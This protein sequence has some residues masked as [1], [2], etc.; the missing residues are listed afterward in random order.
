MLPLARAA[1]R[2]GHEVRFATG[3]DLVERVRSYGFDVHS[4]GLSSQEINDR[5]NATYSD[6]DDLPPHERL[7]KVVPRL[8][9]DIGARASLP[10]ILALVDEW[11]PDLIVS[12]QSESAGP[13]VATARGIPGV[14]HGWGPRVPRALVDVVIPAIEALARE[15]FP[16]VQPDAAAFPY[17]D[18]CPPGLQV[19][20]DPV[21]DTVLPLRHEDPPVDGASA[22]LPE[23]LIYVTLGTV[24]NDQEGVFETVL[25]GLADVDAPILVTVGPDVDPAR[26]AGFD[27][28]VERFVPQG[29]VFPHCR[30]VV[31]HA[32]AG[33]MLG[34]LAA[35]L[36][37]VLLPAGAEQFL[38][39]AA[40]ASAGAAEVTTP[41]G[42]G[43]A[44]ARLGESHL[45]AAR[46][47][48]TEIA[49]MPTADETLETLLSG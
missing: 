3:P 2:A 19:E 41:D 43:E 22:D 33:T 48:Q 46:R 36:P 13:I 28:M 15:T 17:V 29:L 26:L 35:G 37:Q 8:F 38:N 31:A 6:T 5:Y 4:V 12:E 32:G 20:P 7:P 49:A 16:G 34:A 45:A 10:D 27:V 1:L 42:V 18:I 44:F 21:W 11:Q 14:I 40:C 47:L 9:V 25:E 39:A 23:G 24:V 30:A